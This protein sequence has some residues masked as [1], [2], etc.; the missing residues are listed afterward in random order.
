MR[1]DLITSMSE[2]DS[3]AGDLMNGEGY[4]LADGYTLTLRAEPDYDSS[5]YEEEPDF[6]GLLEPI[7]DRRHGYEHRPPGFDGAARKLSGFTYPGDRVWWQPPADIKSDREAC[8]KLATYIVDRMTY[9]YS[10]LWVELSTPEA[11][12]QSS[13]VGGV[14]EPYPELIGELIAE[15]LED[16]RADVDREQASAWLAAHRARFAA[17]AGRCAA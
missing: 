10:V 6:V 7:D 8:D 14:D 13:P 16:Y 11:E 3:V 1:R 17:I 15:V 2:L 12:Y 5:I 4:E 9:G